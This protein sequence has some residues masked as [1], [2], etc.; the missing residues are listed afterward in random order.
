M[1]KTLK[2]E[3]IQGEILRYIGQNPKLLQTAVLSDE[4]LLNRH[5]RTITKVRGEY[6]TLYSLISHI[7]QGFNSKKWTPYGEIQ[8]RKK[9]MKNYHQKIDFELDP[10]E[11]IGTVIQAMYD[12]GK[13]LEQKSI[14][15]HAI[16]LLLK[17]IISDVNILSIEGVYNAS[18]IGLDQPEFGYSMDGLNEIIKKGLANT[19]NPYFLIPAEALTSTNIIEVITEYERALPKFAKNRITKIFMSQTDKE[20]YQLAYEDRF[21]QNKF[22]DNAT[23][24]R[25]GKREIVGIPGLKDGTIIST[26]EN[27]FV[28]MVDLIDNPATITDVQVDK[29]ILNILGEFTLGYDFAINELTYVY[30]TD[31]S[32]KRGLNNSDLNK[33]YYPEEKLIV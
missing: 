14:S 16:D 12:E 10:A 18:K 22:Q 1:N 15:K 23:R 32:K 25:L 3:Q 5:A 13:S 33:L 24:T 21:G 28:K 26:I 29:R 19:E 4:I 20:T 27:G 2:T 7:V 8:F 9:V 11:I 6:P 30:T 31:G 17:K